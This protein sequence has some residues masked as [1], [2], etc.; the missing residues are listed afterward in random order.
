MRIIFLTIKLVL[1]GAIIFVFVMP[2]KGEVDQ[3]RLNKREIDA[4]EASARQYAAV[5]DEVVA[6]YKSLSAEQVE[7][8]RKMVPDTVD[9]VR[10]VN[11]INVIAKESGVTLKKVDY[12]PGEINSPE[13][14]N[15]ENRL[16]YGSYTVR[17]V[18]SGPYKNFLVFVE[19][20]ENSLRIIDIKSIS[21]NASANPSSN[22]SIDYNDYTVTTKAYWLRN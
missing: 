15:A 16:P 13:S 6:R 19:S 11:D 5:S 20:L 8:L 7:R 18:V 14:V 17:F 3:L 12:D 21:F 2:I 22:V 4:T 1:A 9:N 10:L